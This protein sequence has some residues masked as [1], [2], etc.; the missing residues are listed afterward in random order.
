MRRVSRESFA[1]AEGEEQAVQHSFGIELAEQPL[2]RL[3]GDC[4]APLPASSQSP[5]QAA[6][7]SNPLM[8]PIS[9]SAV[10]FAAEQGGLAVAGL[11]GGES[12]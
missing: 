1:D 9:A 7:V 12:R 10:A 8:A 6:A 5:P 3:R 4:E 2:Q 11:L